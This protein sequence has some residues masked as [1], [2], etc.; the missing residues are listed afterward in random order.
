MRDITSVAAPESGCASSRA[1]AP[2]DW[3]TRSSPRRLGPTGLFRRLRAGGRS[4]WTCGKRAESWTPWTW[5]KRV[6]DKTAAILPM[7]TGRSLANMQAIV[8]V[9]KARGFRCSKTAPSLSAPRSKAGRRTAGERPACIPL[10]LQTI[11]RDCPRG[12]AGYR[13]RADRAAVP[14]ASQPRPG[15]RGTLRP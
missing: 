13:R 5:K 2:C 3:Q 7:H 10:P 14:A 8:A 4:S 9:A 15:R 1:R 11:A 6:T 12:D